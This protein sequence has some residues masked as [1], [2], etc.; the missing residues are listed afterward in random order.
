MKTKNILALFALSL[1]LILIPFAIAEEKTIIIGDYEIVH[2]YL[3]AEEGETF[4]LQLEVTNLDKQ[5]KSEI[6]FEINDKNPFK[7]KGDDSWEIGELSSEASVLKTF[8]IE[9]DEDVNEDEY[10]LEFTIE[11]S[12]D[13][14]TD[15]FDIEVSSSNAEL[16]I[17]NVVSFPL[18][19]S[20]DTKD[21]KLEVTI[22][23][24]GG[25]DATF[26]RA[27][28]VLPEGFEAS[29]SYSDS[30]NIGTIAAKSSKVA[31]FY[32]D[33][34]D[35]TKSGL[36]TANIELEYESNSN[37]KNSKLDFDLP[38][39]GKP[40]FYVV[41]SDSVPLKITPGTTGTINIKIQNT[42]EEKGEGTSVRVFE[43]SDLPISFNEKTNFIGNLN[44]GESG[45][46]SFSFEVDE[47]AIAKEY[48]VKVQTRSVN[49]DN[50]LIEEHTIPIKIYESEKRSIVSILPLVV[51]GVFVIILAV[52]IWV[53]RKNKNKQ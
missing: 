28:L 42:G 13:E 1:F 15:E 14:Y 51:L 48:K 35:K 3:G 6:V 11:D 26:T 5:N 44:T 29:S 53:L 21:V 23:N 10:S 7:V 2:S 47:N 27:K 12:E 25:G 50:V 17:G 52:L 8:R 9:I 49:N 43:N 22:E 18:I 30:A 4:T 41:S 36:N 24:L 46:A 45:S 38:V 37:R 39:K 16:I 40:Q 20:P 34:L 31:I 33:V 19:I 32:I